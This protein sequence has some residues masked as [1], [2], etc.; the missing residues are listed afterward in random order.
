MSVRRVQ[1]RVPA[2]SANLGP[3]FDCL[4]LALDLWGTLTFVVA[5]APAPQDGMGRLATEAAERLFACR[6]RSLPP[7]HVAYDGGV[8]VARGLGAS[9]VARVGGLLAACALLGEAPDPHALLPLAAELEGHADNAA[10]ALLGGFQVTVAADGGGYICLGFPPPPGLR[11]VLLVPRQELPTAEAR[12]V[13]P[14]QVPRADA[15]YNVARAALLAASLASGRLEHLREATRDRLHQPYRSRL[16]P[17]LV[18]LMQAALDAGALAAYLSG[19]GPTVCALTAGQEGAVAQALTDAARRL[20]VEG[21][22][23]VTALADRG[24]YLQSVD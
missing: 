8:P 10:P 6:G 1:V 11:A 2:T 20:G 7:L 21:D 19:A 4:G 23:I 5:E 24:A 15:V 9:A 13:L 17:A 14:E 3:G 12:R 16:F 18:P 22:A